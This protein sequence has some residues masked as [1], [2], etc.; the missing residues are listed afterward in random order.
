MLQVSVSIYMFHMCSYI[1]DRETVFGKYMYGCIHC[2]KVLKIQG[3]IILTE[4][5][6]QVHVALVSACILC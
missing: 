2:R 1:I 5:S 3:Q 4:T 6:N